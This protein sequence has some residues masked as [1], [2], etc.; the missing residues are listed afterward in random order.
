[1]IRHTLI[2]GLAGT[3][4]GWGSGCV[5]QAPKTAEAEKQPVETNATLRPLTFSELD[6][7]YLDG[8]ISPEQHLKYLD[9]LKSDITSNSVG[10][11][12]IDQLLAHEKSATN[13]SSKAFSHLQTKV[14]RL[15]ELLRLYIDDKITPDEMIVRRREIINGPD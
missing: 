3:L 11:A 6:Q 7:L 10:E 2:I 14:E 12:K 13:I 5:H 8:K 4:I 15:V 9:Q 1:M